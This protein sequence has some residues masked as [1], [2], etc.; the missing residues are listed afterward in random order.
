MFFIKLMDFVEHTL[1]DV[2][3]GNGGLRFECYKR[4]SVGPKIACCCVTMFMDDPS[5][6]VEY[7]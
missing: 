2:P 1:Y 7:S 6:S 5:Y 4:V 3:G